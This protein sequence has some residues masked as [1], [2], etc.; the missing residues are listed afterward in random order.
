MQV[1]NI[2][3]NDSIEFAIVDD[4]SVSQEIVQKQVSD[5]LE[6][7]KKAYFDRNRHAFGYCYAETEEERK[8]R[9]AEAWSN[10]SNRCYWHVHTVSADLCKG[11]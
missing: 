7:L 4:G 3:M 6:A 2:C 8:Q 1:H 11:A 9:E 10:Y 5:K